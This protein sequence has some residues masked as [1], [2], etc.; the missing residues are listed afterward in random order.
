MKSSK[1]SNLEISFFSHATE[2]PE[3]VLRAAK[4]LFPPDL[5]IETEFKSS[6]LR[7]YFGNPIISFKGKVKR[8]EA[9]ELFK[10]IINQLSQTERDLIVRDLGLYMDGSN[11]YLR[12]N[13]QSAYRKRFRLGKEDPIR[14]KVRF[15]TKKIDEVISIIG[16]SNS[17]S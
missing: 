4:N 7:G 3:K 2:D 8:K 9:F 14:I 1:V 6:K 5:K 11:L 17:R 12:L 15:K 10:Y 13:K 16:G